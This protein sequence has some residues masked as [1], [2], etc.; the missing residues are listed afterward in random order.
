MAEVIFLAEMG[1]SG[2]WH[3]EAVESRGLLNLPAA[4]GRYASAAE[5]TRAIVELFEKNGV[6]VSS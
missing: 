2:E 4:T 3:K 6:A 5:R 1:Y